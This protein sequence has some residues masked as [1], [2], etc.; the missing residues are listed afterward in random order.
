MKR[1]H[2]FRPPLPS[3][4][5]PVRLSTTLACSSPPRM[6][7]TTLPNVP[8]RVTARIHKPFSR[9]PQA[10][11]PS[12]PVLVKPSTELRR[13]KGSMRDVSAMVNAPS[14]PAIIP[15]SVT[16]PLVPGGTFRR[17]REVIKRGWLLD[18]I[19]SSLEKVSA[20]TAA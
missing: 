20:A 11:P 10:R 4:I 8:Q 5:L 1:V 6:L 13:Q 15:V 18:R 9:H 19:P 3:T 14:A 2:T 7:S 17:V 12:R 16:P